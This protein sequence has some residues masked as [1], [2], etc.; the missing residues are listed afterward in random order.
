MWLK[1]AIRGRP[2][3][4]VVLAALGSI[5]FVLASASPVLAHSRL[6]SPAPRSTDDG[7]SDPNGPCGFDLEADSVVIV[8]GSLVTVDWEETIEHPGG[9]EFRFSTANDTGFATVK[10][11]DHIPGTTPTRE[12]PTPYSTSIAFPNVETT[13]GTLQMIQWLMSTESE[14]WPPAFPQDGQRHY[15]CADLN[16]VRPELTVGDETFLEGQLSHA[17]SVALTSSIALTEQQIEVDHGATPVSATNTDFSSAAGSAVIDAETTSTNIPVTI[18]GDKID[19]SN[20]TFVVTLS[21]PVNSE[22][23]DDT[24][25]VTIQDDDHSRAIS[26]RLRRHLRATGL[27][28]VLDLV[29]QCRAAVPVQIQR[30]AAGRWRTLKSVTTKGD[31]T[32]STSVP[33]RGGRYRARMKEQTKPVGGYDHVCLAETSA[34]RTHKHG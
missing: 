24:A 26:L 7:I 18:N 19:E 6:T 20:E 17:E 31:G 12:D 3:R 33:D 4:S 27:V 22:I 15:S 11:V 23:V 13:D 2:P 14:S 9:F 34:I 25:T 28:T 30:R 5:A 1:R 21:D 29:G 8:P 10:M 32:F 16:L